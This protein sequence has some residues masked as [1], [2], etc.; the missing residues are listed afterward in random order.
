MS[1]RQ[2]EA[3]TFISIGKREKA[4][5]CGWLCV[6]VAPTVDGAQEAR[7]CD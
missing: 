4:I 6:N 5:P 1:G 2:I 3:P 7:D